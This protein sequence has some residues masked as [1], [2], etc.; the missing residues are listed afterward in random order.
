MRMHVDSGGEKIYGKLLLNTLDLSLA[1]VF[2]GE[3]YQLY[4]TVFL[5]IERKMAQDYEALT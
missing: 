5:T 1:T 3:S 2:P 4:G